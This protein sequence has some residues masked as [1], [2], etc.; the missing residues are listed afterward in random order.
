[1]PCG[2]KVGLIYVC[3]LV[4]VAPT[5]GEDLDTMV[6]RMARIGSSWSPSFSP[7]GSRLAFVSDLTGVPQVWT[8]PTQGGFPEQV[9]S[10]D[11]SPSGAFRGPRKAPG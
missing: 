10:L 1:M 6:T 8:I 9:T 4:F 11:D 5:A 7:D 3:L 2:A